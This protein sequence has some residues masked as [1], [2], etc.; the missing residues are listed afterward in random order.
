[1]GCLQVNAL[2]LFCVSLTNGKADLVSSLFAFI[3]GQIAVSVTMALLTKCKVDMY[4]YRVEVERG[5]EREVEWRK[6][7]APYFCLD[8]L[9]RRQIGVDSSCGAL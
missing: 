6:V 5:L 3:V 2:F 8:E 4:Q 9:R 1:M 7:K